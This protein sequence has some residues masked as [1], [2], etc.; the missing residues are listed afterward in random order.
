MK[1]KWDGDIGRKY[2]AQ[3]EAVKS[4]W[5]ETRS[6]WPRNSGASPD[7]RTVVYA[8]ISAALEDFKKRSETGIKTFLAQQQQTVHKEEHNSVGLELLRLKLGLQLYL[9]LFIVVRPTG[10]ESAGIGEL[11]HF[12]WRFKLDQRRLPSQ[13]ANGAVSREMQ[14]QVKDGILSEEECTAAINALEKLKR[15]GQDQE[16][17]GEES[18]G[19]TEILG[20]TGYFQ[21]GKIRAD[22]K[23]IVAA[24]ANGRMA[25]EG[26]FKTEL[27]HEMSEYTLRHPGNVQNPHGDNCDYVVKGGDMELCYP[28]EG[29]ESP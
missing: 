29:H 16:G 13:H 20:K 3:V 2:A 5:S 19:Y 26:A 15:P 4:L 28:T 1:I 14:I 27:Y 6:L 24:R 25:A 11:D 17:A 21:T 12:V 18:I 22:T 23:A 7:V 10:E 8:G 9:K